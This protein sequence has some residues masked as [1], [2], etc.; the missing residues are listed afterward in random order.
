MNLTGTLA[1]TKCWYGHRRMVTDEL[2]DKTGQ[3]RGLQISSAF[4]H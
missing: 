2:K 4:A 3:G 1:V